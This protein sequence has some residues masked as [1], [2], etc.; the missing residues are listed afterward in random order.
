MRLEVIALN[1]AFQTLG[2]VFLVFVGLYLRRLRRN[3]RLTE[4]FV[5]AYRRGDYATA[6][7][8]ADGFVKVKSPREYW[9]FRGG[10]LMQLGQFDEAE[11]ALKKAVAFAPRSKAEI[12][13]PALDQETL[14]L[15]YLEQCRYDDAMKWFEASLKVWQ[16]GSAYRDIAEVC[17]RRGDP[18]AEALKWAMLAVNEDRPV[19][20]A[21]LEVHD[22]NLGADLATLAWVVAVALQD[23]AHVDQLAAEALSFADDLPVADSAQIHFHSGLAFAALGD[24]SRSMQCFMEAAQID[25]QGRWGRAARAR[26]TGSTER[27][28]P[29]PHG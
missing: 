1:A 24:A 23:K 2:C 13:I 26:A 17:L 22:M 25:P 8:V 18:P 19:Q 15:L 29:A 14:G 6:L 28:V 7:Q 16:R 27:E 21:S 12:E 4:S 5:D 3:R 20:D 11:S 10:A 9:A